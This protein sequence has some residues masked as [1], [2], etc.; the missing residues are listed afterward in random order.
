MI[1]KG[2]KKSNLG[3]HIDLITG[4]PFKSEKYTEAENGIR[5]LRGDN[6][7]QGQIRWDDVKRWPAHFKEGLNK[8]WLKHGD[9]VIAMDRTWVNSGLKATIVTEDDL[10]CLLVQR[11][12][13]LRV[14]N[15]LDSYF[16]S[17]LI[18]NYH[19]EQYVKGVQ[20]ET[21]V[22][23]ISS[24]QI[25]EFP[26]LLPPL[27]EQ[28]AIAGVLSEWDRAISTTE[29]LIHA[30]EKRFKW[31]MN[32]LINPAD[33]TGWKTVKLGDV[34]EISSAGVDKKIN[35]NE[36]PVR[37]VNYLDVYRRDLIFS[38]ELT[39]QVT[40][41]VAKAK[42]CAVKKGDVF[43]TPS[44]EVRDD[45]G[46]SAVAMEDIPDA[47]YSYH[48][49]RLRL[50]ENWGL[51]YR[52]YAFKSRDFYKQAEK[53][54]DGSGQRYVLSQD[55]FRQ[56]EIIIPPL[57]EQKRIGETLNLAQREIELLKK[58]AEKQ[59]LQKRGLMQK[60]LT[61]EWRATSLITDQCSLNNEKAPDE[62]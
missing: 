24:K 43:F 31:L 59:K 20:T 47:V 23:H 36:I 45:I 38:R 34:G 35:E 61:G 37:L 48:I 40:A 4:F 29:R 32:T 22:P 11:V 56:M 52:A 55:D 3:E 44:S 53:L 9:F 5:L 17:V 16:L 46:H 21:A 27:S 30:K 14:K 50:H 10:P 2:W 8:F 25:H 6:V 1:P 62:K 57:S 41:P 19:F 33:K 28:K 26:V 49:V 13:R 18:R 60:L 7:I 42:K 58:L 51:L 54:C 39:H 15:E 12:A